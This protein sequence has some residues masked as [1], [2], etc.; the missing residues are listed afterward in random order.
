MTTSIETAFLLISSGIAVGF[1]N[2]LAGGGTI[3]S[4]TTFMAMGLPI[5]TAAG[6]NR[7][8]I[9]MQNLVAS[10]IFKKKKMFSFKAAFK[11]CLPMM[12]GALISAQFT[13]MLDTTIFSYIFMAG[14]I[15]FAFLLFNKADVWER[16]ESLP[17]IRITKRERIYMF[18]IGLYAGSI[19]VGMG[20]MVLSVLVLSMGYDVIRANAM[21]NMMALILG[22]VAI[23]PFIISGNVNYEMGLIHGIGNIIGAYLGTT[24]AIKL[25]AKFIRYLLVAMVIVSLINTALKLI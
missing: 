13:I 11:I 14:L 9:I 8:P 22:P 20:Y 15:F 16:T 10:I 3:I 2:T 23:I 1:I 24:F 12:I 6:T 21:K 5:V 25:G 18:L 7:I 4:I 17:N 19:Y